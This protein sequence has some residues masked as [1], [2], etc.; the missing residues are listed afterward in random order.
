VSDFIRKLKERRIQQIGAVLV[1]I[2]PGGTTG[3]AAFHSCVLIAAGFTENPYEVIDLLPRAARDPDC[4]VIE[5]PQHRSRKSKNFADIITLAVLVG[6][7]KNMWRD[8]CH[9]VEPVWP[10]TWK[11]SVPKDIHNDRVLEK[12]SPKERDVL[13]KSP[14]AKKFNHN[15]IDAVGIGLWKLG[16]M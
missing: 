9:A 2:D 1:A 16:R 14:R 12:L 4:V 13:Q 8:R 11:G 7:L 6:E 5:L 15:M 10:T 3:W